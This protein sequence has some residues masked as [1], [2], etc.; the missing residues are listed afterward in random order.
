DWSWGSN[1]VAANEGV[2]LLQAFR[3]TADSS[4]LD[5][6]VAALDYLL[7]RNPTGYSFVT[8]Y[9]AKTPHSPHH[10]P[11][12]SDT[13]AAPVP[14]LLV[15]GPNPGQQ[16]RCAGYPSRL[17]ALSYLDDVCAYASNE[18]AINWNAPFAYLALAIDAIYNHGTARRPPR[19]AS[20]H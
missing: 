3:L 13:V 1:G 16:D 14:G 6:A 8:G 7:G 4:Y 19:T 10:R 2:A 9:G 12:A 5:A 11:S 20:A 15:G 17:P 18:I